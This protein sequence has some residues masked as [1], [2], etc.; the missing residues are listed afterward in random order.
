MC[1]ATELRTLTVSIF[2]CESRDISLVRVRLNKI[3]YQAVDIKAVDFKR[4]ERRKEEAVEGR[5]GVLRVGLFP[6]GR[7]GSRRVVVV[8]H[9]HHFVIYNDGALD[10]TKIKVEEDAL[11][12]NS[13]NKAKWAYTDTRNSTFVFFSF[14]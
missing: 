5:T 12:H 11:G 14:Q 3:H 9:H 13:R 10:I 4:G 6:T 2:S 8:I 7:V 1:E